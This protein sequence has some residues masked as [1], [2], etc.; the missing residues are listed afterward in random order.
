MLA[1]MNI[2]MD[3]LKA[4]SYGARKKLLLGKHIPNV[5]NN[6]RIAVSIIIEEI[7]HC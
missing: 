4:L 7:D 2:V 3:L 5:G 6:R 1:L